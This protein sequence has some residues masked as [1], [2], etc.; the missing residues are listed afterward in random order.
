MPLADFI[1]A[2]QVATEIAM[3]SVDLAQA[4][5]VYQNHRGLAFIDNLVEKVRCLDYACER[6]MTFSSDFDDANGEMLAAAMQSA[7]SIV[8]EEID[9]K[10]DRLLLEGLS[11]T[12]LAYYELANIV[13]LLRDW[14]IRPPEGSE[15]EYA[16]CCRN[17]FLVHP[18]LQRALP[19]TFGGVSY[20]RGKIAEFQIVLSSFT[21]PGT[22]PPELPQDDAARRAGRWENEKL[23]RS[24]RRVEKYTDAEVRRLD[25]YGVKNPSLSEATGE[26]AL[27]LM[28][29][30]LPRLES[31][32]QRAVTE[33]G[34]EPVRWSGED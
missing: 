23:V 32:C 30:A 9:R 15:L 14:D 13:T 8:P 22:V 2:A 31:D 18:R 10:R 16:V 3:P 28:A 29:R 26:L 12:F 5:A 1:S 27:L 24:G 20:A 21:V 34:Y 17:V 19:P 7:R 11:L 33:C 6:L 25:A 4:E